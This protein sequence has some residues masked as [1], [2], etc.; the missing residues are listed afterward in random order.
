MATTPSEIEQ[1]AKQVTERHGQSEDF[2]ERFVTFYDNTITNNLG[3][4]SLERLIDSV[5]L[6][7]GEELDGS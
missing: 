2:K 5:D 3:G 4:T 1:I 7:E 6:P